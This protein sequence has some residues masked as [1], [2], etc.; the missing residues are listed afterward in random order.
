[1]VSQFLPKQENVSMYRM[2]VVS[3]D[4]AQTRS[5]INIK[6][7][8][9]LCGKK[10]NL[11]GG[12]WQSKK[13]ATPVEVPALPRVKSVSIHPRVEEMLGEQPKGE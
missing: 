4:R 1:M 11:V 5:A 2:N 6:E 10:E 9:C 12:S 8:Y 7:T 13:Y 3:V